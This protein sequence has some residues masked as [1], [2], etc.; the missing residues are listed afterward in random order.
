MF[1]SKVIDCTHLKDI[2]FGS[3]KVV[4][5]SDNSIKE[6]RTYAISAVHTSFVLPIRSKYGTLNRVIRVE[7]RS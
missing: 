1:T 3:R 7:D 2:N 4:R 6:Y 5:Y